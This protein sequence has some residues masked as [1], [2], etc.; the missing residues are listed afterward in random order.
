MYLGKL[1]KY[2]DECNVYRNKNKNIRKPIFIVRNVFCNRGIKGWQNCKRFQMYEAGK[3][4]PD[5]MTPN[6]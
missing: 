5:E 6:G 2:S 3:P 1:C 4:V